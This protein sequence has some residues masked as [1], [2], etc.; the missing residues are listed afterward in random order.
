MP[1]RQAAR[2]LSGI[3]ERG[4]NRRAAEVDRTNLSL[5][6]FV[7]DAA[8]ALPLWCTRR[9][10]AAARPAG[11]P[12]ERRRSMHTGRG[13]VVQVGFH[14]R[15]YRMREPAVFHGSHVRICRKARL[16]M[17]SP[18]PAEKKDGARTWAPPGRWGRRAPRAGPEKA[19]S[20]QWRWDVRVRSGGGR[21][22]ERERAGAALDRPA[23]RSSSGKGTRSDPIS[24]TQC[25]WVT[26]NQ[27]DGEIALTRRDSIFNSVYLA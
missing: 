8:V 6:V 21:A 23:L 7:S 24:W 18:S 2:S 25:R 14:A 10:E 22:G 26:D 11:S 9:R 17:S 15:A 4:K 3:S 16:N 5:L 27:Q 1:S 13:R 20:F 19:A 12:P